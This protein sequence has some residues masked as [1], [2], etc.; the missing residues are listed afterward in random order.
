VKNIL[1]AGIGTLALSNQLVLAAQDPFNLSIEQLLN[2][3]VSVAS[4]QVTK[5]SDAPGMIT[6][7]TQADIERL[8]YY[9]IKELAS[10]TPGFSSANIH[11]GQGNLTVRGQKVEGFDNNKVLVLLDGLP[12]NHLRNGRAPIDEDL[13]LVGVEKVEFLKGPGS[14]LYGTGAFL[15]VVNITTLRAGSG[16]RE[17]KAM[18]SLGSFDSKS[19]RT[20]SA[21]NNENLSGKFRASFYSQNPTGE[22]YG[23]KSGTKAYQK[24]KTRTNHN[25]DS[26]EDYHFDGSVEINKGALKGLT[27]GF[28]KSRNEH[29]TFE[30]LSDYNNYSYE[31]STTSI[32]SKIKK[33]INKNLLVSGYIRRTESIEEGNRYNYNFVFHGYDAQFETTYNISSKSNFI[34]GTS[35]DYRFLAD[36][37]KGTKQGDGTG[38]NA[39]VENGSGPLRTYS[40]YSQYSGE[41]DLHR[42]LLVTLGVRYDEVRSDYAK[43][44]KLSPRLALVQRLTGDMN[45][46]F[47]FASAL[48]SPDLKS[49]LINAGVVEEGGALIQATLDAETAE[50]FELGVT[51]NNDNYSSS[52]SLFHVV[53]KDALNRRSFAGKDSYRNDTGDTISQ[54][55]ELEN[56]LLINKN[57]DLF[58]NGTYAKSKLDKISSNTSING[59]EVE[60]TP[61]TSVNVG[62]HFVVG[63][64]ATTLVGKYIDEFRVGDMS[65]RDNGF[66]ILDLNSV[67]RYD[68][69]LKFTF[70]V[71]NSLGRDVRVPNFQ[72]Q[73]YSR[74]FQVGAILS[75]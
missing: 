17:N 65:G 19:A 70:K 15:G 30:A 36:K 64:V 46:K 13:S 7:Y 41:L 33:S 59:Q 42:G 48:R 4:K 56:K 63:S 1:K 68:N 57:F 52:F 26:V 55:F 62:G 60:G 71:S 58:I 49:T 43:S 8:G 9:T 20:Y 61:R 12:V 72:E 45:L 53:V 37:D 28:F 29:G 73:Y 16:D 74:L 23:Y 34:L 39:F 18:F 47:L 67:Y 14:A 31:F 2:L 32:Y 38:A 24:S 6:V 50:S 69:S 51:Y 11:A 3:D 40:L 25:F 66:F 21:F 5:Q 27:F 22:I 44:S 10:V 54:G 35:L 75:F